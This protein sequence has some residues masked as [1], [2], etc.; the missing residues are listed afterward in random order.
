VNLLGEK[1]AIVTGGSRGIGRAIARSYAEYGAKV[2]VSYASAD[3][4]ADSLVADARRDG[5]EVTAIKGSVSD[6]EYVKRLVG[7][8]KRKHGRVD[9]LVNNAGITRDGF[10]MMMKDEDWDDVV[11]VNLKGTFLCSR[12]VLK[13]MIAQKSGRIINMT[14]VTGVVGQAGQTNY[15]ASKGGIIGFTKAL[16]REVARFGI[17]VNAIAPGFIETDMIRAMPAEI[18][19]AG[20]RL[21]PLQRVGQ[22]GEVAAAAVFLASPMSSYTTGHVLHVDGGQ[23]M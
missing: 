22:A 15:A 11:D 10:L 19:A 1:V 7:E 6:A 21:V 23:A 13:P 14:S 4:A 8:A 12:E 18:L 17:G 20:V 2:V 3:E 16:A 5:L 9:I